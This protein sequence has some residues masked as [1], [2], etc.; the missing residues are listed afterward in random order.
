MIFRQRQ[1]DERGCSVCSGKRGHKSQTNYL[2]SELNCT[3]RADSLV[4]FAA[5]NDGGFFTTA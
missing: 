3:E 2:E 1:T 5:S 4:L